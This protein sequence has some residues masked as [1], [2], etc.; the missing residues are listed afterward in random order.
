MFPDC[1]LYLGLTLVDVKIPRRGA[2]WLEGVRVT[3]CGMSSLEVLL[4]TVC[5]LC[6]HFFVLQSGP[7]VH[8]DPLLTSMR[9]SCDVCLLLERWS[10]EYVQRS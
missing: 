8:A 5:G 6:D 7:C 2:S 4:R 1:C 9:T 10:V 3:P